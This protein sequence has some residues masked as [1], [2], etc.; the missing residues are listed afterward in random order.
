M[1]SQNPGPTTIVTT[2]TGGSRSLALQWSVWA[3][4]DG[5]NDSGTVYTHNTS[6]LHATRTLPGT[7]RP[8]SGVLVSRLREAHKTRPRLQS[9]SSNAGLN[10]TLDA[11]TTL[12]I[13]Q[14]C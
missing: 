14:L 1:I 5:V 10:F 9:L 12:F 11:Y 8:V 3:F 7:A 13:M 4:G 2:L 6:M